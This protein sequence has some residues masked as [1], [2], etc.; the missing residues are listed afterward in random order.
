MAM[1][2][3]LLKKI[4][5]LQNEIRALRPLGQQEAR[6]LRNYFKIG[7]TYSSNA[8]EGNTLTETE[9]KVVLEDGLTIGGKPLIYHLEAIGHAQAYDYMYELATKK[10]ITEADICSLHRLFYAGIN[11]EEAGVYR[12]RQVYITGTTFIPVAPSLVDKRM[13]TFADSIPVLQ[14]TLH[15]VIYAATLHKELVTIH[16]FVDG[17]GRTARLVMNLALL[18]SGYVVTIIPP[19]CRHQ[20]IDTLKLSQCSGNDLPFFELVA[21]AV[22]ESQKDYKRLIGKDHNTPA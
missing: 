13:H 1:L 15:P 22:Y 18:Q 20:Y 3:T 4:D 14:K 11:K 7:L 19:I 5:A 17:N 9:T 8:L 12:T 2:E 6:E 21:S 10:T 16:P